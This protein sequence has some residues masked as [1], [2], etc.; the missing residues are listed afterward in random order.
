M[1]PTILLVDDEPHVLDALRTM[2]RGQPYEVLTARSGPDALE[3]LA[4][5]GV[6]VVVS[7]ERMAPMSGST[8][9]RLCRERFPDTERIVLTGHA[10]LDAVVSAINDAQVVAFLKKP[11]D[12]SELVEA[13][14]LALQSQAQRRAAGRSVT[15]TMI[16]NTQ[17]DAALASAELWYQPIVDANEVIVAHEALLRPQST[18]L[19]TP[20]HVVDTASA[21]GRH[22]DLDRRVRQI[23]AANLDLGVPARQV[24]INV[25]PESLVDGALF[26]DDALADHGDRV[27]IEITERAR[28]GAIADIKPAVAALRERGHR[29]AVDD[30][31]AGYA[32]L[33][34]LAV[35]QPDVVKFDLE[36]IRDIN[37]DAGRAHLVSAMATICRELGIV[38]LAEGIETPSELEVLRDMGFDLYQGY[39]LGKPA[40]GLG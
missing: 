36:L 30:L 8:F 35:L 27:V 13:V 18:D 38:T 19:P 37:N 4:G 11:C 7:D 28:L 31:G 15:D 39:L 25:L 3:V 2:L 14:D 34:S 9:L 21:L 17:L 12:L 6:D 1:K 20:T 5:T 10:S 29:V 26:D 32:G 33:T 22:A 23:A 16:A 40:P 24:F